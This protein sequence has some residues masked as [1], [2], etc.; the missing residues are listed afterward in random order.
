M[1]VRQLMQ[2]LSTLDEHALVYVHLVGKD[3]HAT[4]KIKGV[5]AVRGHVLFVAELPTKIEPWKG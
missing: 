4:R 3:G 5:S 1:T 2:A